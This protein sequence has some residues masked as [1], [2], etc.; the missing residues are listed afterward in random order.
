MVNGTKHADNLPQKL[1]ELIKSRKGIANLFL[2]L[3]KHNTFDSNLNTMQ[4]IPGN[5]PPLPR[6]FRD[7]EPWEVLKYFIKALSPTKKICY[8]H[9][10]VVLALRLEKPEEF[11]NHVEGKNI[12]TLEFNEEEL[13]GLVDWKHYPVYKDKLASKQI[14]SSQFILKQSMS[15]ENLDVEVIVFCFGNEKAGELES[16]DCAH[17]FNIKP[18]NELH[19]YRRKELG[20]FL[21]EL[22]SPF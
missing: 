19:E 5:L 17:W 6:F 20:K 3:N 1:L 8:V 11:R 10:N 9:D 4:T 22:K 16:L 12:I 13:N 15:F 2:L 7:S 14:P 18:K 21:N